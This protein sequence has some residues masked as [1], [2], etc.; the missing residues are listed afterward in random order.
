MFAPFIITPR[1]PAFLTF[2]E[3]SI[4]LACGGDTSLR[5]KIRPS[6]IEQTKY[7]T[8]HIFIWTFA[9]SFGHYIENIRLVVKIYKLRPAQGSLVCHSQNQTERNTPSGPHTRPVKKKMATSKPKTVAFLGP[10]ASYSHQVCV[11]MKQTEPIF[12]AS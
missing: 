3:G 4:G 7:D 10:A 1:N 6:F 2:Q 8:K 12:I 9:N 5:F 11:M